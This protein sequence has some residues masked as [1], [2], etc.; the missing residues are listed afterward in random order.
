M[1]DA[2]CRQLALSEDIQMREDRRERKRRTER[3]LSKYN[4]QN[5]VLSMGVGPH[6][7]NKILSAK[8]SQ[9][10]DQV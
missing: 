8:E 1:T 7:T 3:T 4:V 6:R 9:S 2:F 10:D 5:L